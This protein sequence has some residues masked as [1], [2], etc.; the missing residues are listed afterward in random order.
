MSSIKTLLAR[1]PFFQLD[2]NCKQWINYSYDNY[3]EK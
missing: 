3:M 2:E 1:S